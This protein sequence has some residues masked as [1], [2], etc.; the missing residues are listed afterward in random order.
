M[1]ANMRLEGSTHGKGKKY[2]L[3]ESSRDSINNGGEFS[4]TR[5]GTQ[6]KSEVNQK[7]SRRG[8]EKETKS[9]SFAGF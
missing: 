4:T 6:R 3:D 5:S 7:S 2:D 8:S 9:M 1:K